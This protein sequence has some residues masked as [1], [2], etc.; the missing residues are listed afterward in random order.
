MFARVAVNVSVISG[1][2][3]YAIPNELALQIQAGSFVIVPFGKQTVQGIV[4][5]LIDSPAVENPKLIIDLLDPAPVLTQPQLALAML[6]ADSTLNP[7]AAIISL[8]LPVGLSQQA[9]VNY[10]LRITNYEDKTSTVTTRLL[11][12]LRE[13]GPLRGRQID[14]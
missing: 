5:A 2:F 8:M 1:L 6:L 7:L 12:L 4:T 13:R 10:E 9:D 14:Y 11:T 3:D